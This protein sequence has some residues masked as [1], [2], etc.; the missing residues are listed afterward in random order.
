MYDDPWLRGEIILLPDFARG[1]AWQGTRWCHRAG[2]RPP[3][4]LTLSVMMHPNVWFV[5]QHVL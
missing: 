2:M 5:G 4:A 1:R 3:V